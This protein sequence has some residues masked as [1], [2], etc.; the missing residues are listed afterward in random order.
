MSYVAAAPELLASAA[1]DLSNVGSQLSTAHAAA[2][3]ATTGLL[4][5]GADEV[6][7]AITA[8]FGSYGQG[9]QALAGRAAAFHDLFVQTLGASAAS[10]TG[11][12]AASVNVLRTV[13]HEILILQPLIQSVQHVTQ[14]VEQNL[15]S[16][17]GSLVW[18]GQGEQFL[19][20]AAGPAGQGLQL[21]GQG[22]EDLGQSLVTLAQNLQN[23]PI[24]GGG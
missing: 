16:I 19:G 6:S 24:S 10:Y 18:I 1:T 7:A 23:L 12:E 11:T 9:Y 15:F 20:E 22:T 17:G 3:E 2:A 5:P 21:L 8:V 13:L 4:A 14:G